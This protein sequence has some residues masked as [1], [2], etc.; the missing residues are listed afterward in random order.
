MAGVEG[1]DPIANL[2]L[3]CRVT[4]QVRTR[5]HANLDEGQPSPQVRSP[6]QH[7]VERI[8]AFRNALGVVE[9]IDAEPDDVGAE[10]EQLAQPLLFLRRL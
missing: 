10:A 7:R 1:V 2:R 5:R 6:G 8:E 4:L 9:P 3:D